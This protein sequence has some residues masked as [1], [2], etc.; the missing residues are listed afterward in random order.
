MTPKQ[1]Q[2]AASKT[3]LKSRAREAARLVLVELQQQAEV[4]RALNINYRAVSRA[5]L[6]IKAEAVQV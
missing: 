2:L 1:F 6:R 5:V 4:A 3:R